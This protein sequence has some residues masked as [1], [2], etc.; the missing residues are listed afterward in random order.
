MNGSHLIRARPVV[1]KLHRENAIIS[2]CSTHWTTEII[3]QWNG[4]PNELTWPFLSG[5]ETL[6]FKR[7]WRAHTAISWC[8]GVKNTHHIAVLYFQFALLWWR[9]GTCGRWPI[10]SLSTCP[11]PTC[12]SPSRVYPRA[13][14]LTSPKHGSSEARSAKSCLTFR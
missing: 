2:L 12:W 7:L 1:L 5:T 6:R 8:V 11:L 4:A 9:T 13:W 3:K 10:T 14:W